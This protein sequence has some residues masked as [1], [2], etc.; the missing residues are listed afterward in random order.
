M[1]KAKFN[2]Y[3]EDLANSIELMFVDAIRKGVAAGLETATKTTVKD[4]GNAV[5]HWQVGIEGKSRAASRKLGKLSDL[6]ETVSGGKLHDWVGKRGDGV[7]KN[8]PLADA[9][10]Q[11]VLDR[12]VK[13]IIEKHVR[14]QRPPLKYYFYNPVGRAADGYDDYA[15]IDAAGAAG[16]RAAV[17]Y[18]E[19]EIAKGST[20]RHRLK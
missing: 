11:K 2:V 4:S 9:I 17:D 15:N 19:A 1:S 7:G 12:E 18:F 13:T 16:V 5:V 3:T 14:G 10:N 20:R 6:R 8:A